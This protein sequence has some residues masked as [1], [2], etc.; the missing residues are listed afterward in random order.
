[1]TVTQFLVTP[2]VGVIPWPY[3]LRPDP[4]EVAGVFHVPLEWLADE[5]HLEIR[6]RDPLAGGP[7]VPV[8]FYRPYQ[9][10]TIWGATARI[11]LELLR[12]LGLRSTEK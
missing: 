2:I 7:P 11:T 10:H 6:L 1:M 9:G 3:A 5:A 4:V 8:S 12:L